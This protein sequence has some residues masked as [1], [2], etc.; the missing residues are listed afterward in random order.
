MGHPRATEQSHHF[1]FNKSSDQIPY[2]ANMKLFVIVC[3]ALIA[4]VNATP[5]LPGP[6]VAPIVPV[7]KPFVGGTYT[8]IDAARNSAKDIAL[9]GEGLDKI[10]RTAR[11]FQQI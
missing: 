7:V 9:A 6:A 1:H 11:C 5:V 2:L 3:L 8:N 10:G 4:A